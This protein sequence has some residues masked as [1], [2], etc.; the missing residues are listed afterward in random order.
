MAK[1]KQTTRPATASRRTG[2]TS[3]KNG[4]AGKTASRP[5][6]QPPA[7]VPEMEVTQQSEE[8]TRLAAGVRH[9]ADEARQQVEDARQQAEGIHSEMQEFRQCAGELAR[10]LYQAEE[11]ARQERGRCEQLHTS[12]GDMEEQFRHSRQQLNEATKNFVTASG[13]QVDEVRQS[14]LAARLEA[15]QIQ[16]EFRGIRETAR[17]HARE[18]EE[19]QRELDGL[20]D[21]SRR[22]NTSWRS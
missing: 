18:G 13:Q 5:R 1:S 21:A 6:K 7:P 3:Q 4:Q 22:S 16:E 19:A 9:E 11:L 14:F 10:E 8:L 2:T 15:E 12:V 20:R 17:H